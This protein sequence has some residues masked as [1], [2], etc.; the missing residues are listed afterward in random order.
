MS[1]WW[2]APVLQGPENDYGQ[3]DYMIE[4]IPKNY[5]KWQFSKYRW[6]CDTCG[7]ER[8]LR[9]VSEEF[10]HTMDGWD[11]FSNA[12]CWMCVFKGWVRHKIWKTKKAIKDQ[13]GILKMTKEFHDGMEGRRDY[14]YCYK[15]AKKLV[16]KEK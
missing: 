10:F 16:K 15:F 1:D 8:H 3:Y 7:K 4:E 6:K 2:K 5:A 14:K 11:S 13:M 12:E 9:F